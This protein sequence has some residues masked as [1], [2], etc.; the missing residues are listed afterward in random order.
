MW[1]IET[2]GG[3]RQKWPNPNIWVKGEEEKKLKLKKKID[4]NSKMCRV[5]IQ[6]SLI[7]NYQY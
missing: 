7:I 4:I 2:S 5:Y 6:K 3:L 1:K